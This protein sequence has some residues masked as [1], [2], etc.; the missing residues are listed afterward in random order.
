MKACLEFWR[1][2]PGRSFSWPEIVPKVVNCCGWETSCR[3][4]E[5]K[6][7]ILS[8]LCPISPHDLELD[9]EPKVLSCFRVQG[10]AGPSQLGQLEIPFMIYLNLLGGLLSLCLGS[11][12]LLP[13]H[14]K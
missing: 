9:L 5:G 14:R 12:Q 13:Q 2:C 4:R 8:W 3:G 7:W 11:S 1:L 6:P 10:G